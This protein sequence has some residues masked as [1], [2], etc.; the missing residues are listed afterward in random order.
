[1]LAKAGD[2]E[3]TLRNPMCSADAVPHRQHPTA[4]YG[5][6]VHG[7]SCQN[8]FAATEV[9]R[10]SCAR[11][12]QSALHDRPPYLDA[13]LARFLLRDALSAFRA[14]CRMN[15][16]LIGPMRPPTVVLRERIS[17]VFSP[18]MIM[19]ST[20]RRW[21]LTANSWPVSRIPQRHP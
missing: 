11:A 13:P 16:F 5:C 3:D 4:A 20:A 9:M 15:P 7:D 21:F 10:S 18:A 1:M 2:G 6:R 8:S 19:R 14:A 12:H 17:H